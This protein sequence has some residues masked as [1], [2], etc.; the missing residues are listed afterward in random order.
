M[1]IK[2]GTDGWRAIIG[3]DYTTDNVA[4]V[5]K[6][7]AQFLKDSNASLSA[8]IGHDTRFGGQLFTE[9]VAKVLVDNGIKVFMA[10]DMIS[11]PMLS[12]ACHKLKTG[13]GIVITASHNP[14]SYNGYKLKSNYGGPTTP[15]DI[16]AVEDLIEETVEIPST[17]VAELIESGN[18]A[19]IN[20]EDLYYDHVLKSFD[21]DKIN[22]S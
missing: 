14:P 10:S 3:K 19:L 2:F 5:A 8:V 22:A 18:I 11:T 1:I 7:T 17:D 13:I 4:R 9:I 21:M 6:A 20:M 12:L 15:V 16:S